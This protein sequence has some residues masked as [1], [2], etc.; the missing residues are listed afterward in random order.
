MRRYPKKKMLELRLS[1]EAAP[2]FGE[3]AEAR[4]MSLAAS[5]DADARVIRKRRKQLLRDH[6]RKETK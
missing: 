2:L 1:P 3:V 5:L 6:G 4:F